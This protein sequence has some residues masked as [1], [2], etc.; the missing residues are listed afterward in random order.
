MPTN[1][2]G[3]FFDLN[4]QR[5]KVDM[6]AS[7]YRPSPPSTRAVRLAPRLPTPAIEPEPEPDRSLVEGYVAPKHEPTLR[8]APEPPPEPPA[9]ERD[10]AGSKKG[11]KRSPE[12]IAR[13]KATIAAKKSARNAPAVIA[14]AEP[15]GKPKLDGLD[16][17]LDIIE[18]CESAKERLTKSQRARL[19][20]AL[21]QRLS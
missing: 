9:E 12:S 5:L 11:R 14:P 17:I 15:V 3:Q 18:L 2:P 1:N 4:A 13:M 21:N 8:S 16:L 6:P 10:M 20:A 7:S 19:R